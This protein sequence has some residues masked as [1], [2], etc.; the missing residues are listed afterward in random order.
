V[1]RWSDDVSTSDG[2]VVGHPFASVEKVVE[3]ALDQARNEQAPIEHE[4]MVLELE[5]LV[6]KQGIFIKIM[7]KKENK[8]FVTPFVFQSRTTKNVNSNCPRRS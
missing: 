2:E 8:T 6:I 5:K 3:A 7:Q 1:H 4:D